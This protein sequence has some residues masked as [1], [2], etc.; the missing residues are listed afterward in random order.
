M[1]YNCGSAVGKVQDYHTVKKEQRNV[2]RLYLEHQARI[3]CQYHAET[4][5][6]MSITI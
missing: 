1:K 3:H 4:S 6:H 5:Q 2:S